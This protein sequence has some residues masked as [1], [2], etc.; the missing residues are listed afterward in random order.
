MAVLELQGKY[1]QAKVFTE[2]VDD[3]TIGQIIE[4]LNQPFSKNAN[5][6][7]M[8]DVHAGKGAVVGTT[9]HILKNEDGSLHEEAKVSPNVV[10]VD[11]GCGMLTV[12][13]E[14]TD[15]DFEKLD[16]VIR[17]YIPYGMEIREKPH[18]MVKNFRF[19]DFHATVDKTIS[20][21][22]CG[23]LGSGNHFIEMAKSEDDRMF[24][25]IHSG[26]R[27]VGIRVASYHQ[28]EAKKQ[29][30]QIRRNQA[31]EK[32]KNTYDKIH[33][34]REIKNL[35][36]ITIQTPDLA[37]L[38]G[39]KLKNYLDDM[40]LAQEFAKLNRAIMMHEI[41]THMNFKEIHRFDTIHN[42]IDLENLILRK[43]AI[44]AQQ[45]EEVLIPINMRDGSILAR[46][47]GNPDWNYSAPHGAGRILSRS[48]A[49]ELLSVDEFK[50]TMK[51]VYTTSV[52]DSTLD[53]AP[54][55]YK[56]IDEIIKNTKDA[57]EIIAILKPIYNFKAN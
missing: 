9:M 33:W 44:S 41:L 39:D 15:V 54:M 27:Y 52:G 47:K 31:I 40:R 12:E 38:V 8:P 43:G 24:I 30:L 25:I 28:K 42:Y 3:A 49:K 34:E 45:G 57:I 7:M 56:P 4:F 21:L 26:S 10:G 51:G 1:D 11:I 23:S 2:N 16:Q 5:V 17:Q 14:P 32:I 18:P 55:A 50:E 6:R 22:A 29:M 13:I 36:H 48:K 20:S 53:E 37:Y 35:K 46:G 19:D